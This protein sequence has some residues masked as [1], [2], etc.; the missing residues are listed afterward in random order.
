MFFNVFRKIGVFCWA[1][2]SALETWTSLQRPSVEYLEKIPPLLSLRSEIIS[3]I[4]SSSGSDARF[5]SNLEPP[6]SYF[7]YRNRRF[8]VPNRDFFA[9]AARY[10]N[11]YSQGKKPFAGGNFAILNL[12]GKWHPRGEICVTCDSTLRI[13]PLLSQLRSPEG[14]VFSLDILLIGHQEIDNASFLQMKWINYCAR[15]LGLYCFCVL[16]LA[17]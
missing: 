5:W 9:P 3:R 6:D 14:E 15:H 10:K 4:F 8:G 16:N 12:R 17:G 7:L 13:Y 2:P 1:H 11:L